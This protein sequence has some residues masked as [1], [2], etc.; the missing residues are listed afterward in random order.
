MIPTY[1]EQMIQQGTARYDSRSFS[2]AQNWL[3]PVETDE[4]IV[5][6]EFYYT[7]YFNAAF[8][9]ADNLIGPL[10][11]DAQDSSQC[12][13]FFTGNNYHPFLF[14][15]VPNVA[16]FA[17]NDEV[18]EARLIPPRTAEH[19]SCYII[20]DSNVNVAITRQPAIQTV[21]NQVLITP[22]FDTVVPTLGYAGSPSIFEIESANGN[23]LSALPYGQP[24]TTNYFPP[25]ISAQG[26][27]QIF[28][29]TPLGAIPDT[30]MMLIDDQVYK[31][32]A[33]YQ[34]TINFVRI[35]GTIPNR[36]QK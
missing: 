13:A 32:A 5:I 11:Y 29:T 34:L 24:A 10:S 14:K 6:Y 1:L 33:A 26:Y 31:M 3:I 22:Q 7:P 17:V 35:K 4:Y 12:V 30:N 9:G 8:Q 2:L 21:L 28:W 15:Q 19:R 16:N 18:Q 23:A 20:S 25:L 36:K 27:N